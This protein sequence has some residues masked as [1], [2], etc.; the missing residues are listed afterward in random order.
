MGD[1]AAA[2][3]ERADQIH[4]NGFAPVSRLDLP[5]R[6]PQR[7]KGSRAVNEEIDATKSVDCARNHRLHLLR[8]GD[9]CRSGQ[10]FPASLV[11]PLSSAVNLGWSTRNHRNRC[12]G[13]CKHGCSF[14]ANTSSTASNDGNAIF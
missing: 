4:F 5:S 6:L 12:P 8:I 10:R 9:V 7:P 11:N 14:C 1:D 13:F 3:Q 2:Q